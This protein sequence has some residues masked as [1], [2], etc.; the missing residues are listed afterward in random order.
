MKC[1]PDDLFDDRLLGRR[2]DGAGEQGQQ[3]PLR[4]AQQG[5]RLFGVERRGIGQALAGRA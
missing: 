3:Q 4:L 5:S 2:R 1:G